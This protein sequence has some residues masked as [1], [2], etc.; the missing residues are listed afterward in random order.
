MKILFVQKMAAIS[1]SEL[2][3]MHLLPE[4]KKRG[5]EV[6]VLIIFPVVPP[7]TKPFIDHFR[8]RGIET[9]EIYGHHALSPVLFFR[10]R[11]LLKK[12]KFDLV[13]SNLVHADLW[14]A[15]QKMLFFKRMRLVSVKHG[16]DEAYSAR[17]G[18]NPAFLKKSLFYWVQKF[19]GYFADY[20]VTISKG[21][22]NI[23]VQGGIVKENRIRNIYYGLD[24]GDKEKKVVDREPEETYALILGR[25][26]QYKGHSMLLEAWKKVKAE[27]PAWKLYIVGGGNYEA[28]LKKQYQ[29]SGLGDSVRFLGYQA[30]PH[31]L[32]KDARFMLVTSTFEGFGLI[33]LEGWVHKKPV[34]GFDVPA[35]NEAVTDGE[36]GRLIPP[37]DT[38]KLARAI[39][40]YFN[41]PDQTKAQGEA[42]YR[43]LHD[44]FTVARMTDEMETVY[45]TVAAKYN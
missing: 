15:L 30:N 29:E 31:Q 44:Y 38:G 13:Q 36:T 4:L 20:N 18:N 37:F 3:L 12:E 25:L 34:I 24:L 16:F 10:L 39:I 7:G 14:L 23:Y 28:E 1:G 42:G 22:Y 17:Y 35:I 11:K 32:I 21:L 26:V 27:N 41:N 43:R 33:M 19:S 2:Y 40:D 45:R 6:K 9:F 5:Y 8:E